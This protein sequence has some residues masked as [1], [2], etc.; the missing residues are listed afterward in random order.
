MGWPSSACSHG[1]RGARR[2]AW[3]W[4]RMPWGWFWAGW[5]TAWPGGCCPGRTGLGRIGKQAEQQGRVQ[6]FPGL[7]NAAPA[8]DK[9]GLVPVFIMLAAGSSCPHGEMQVDAV[10]LGGEVV[11]VKV[12]GGGLVELGD[13]L[14]HHGDDGG[15]AVQV[16]AVDHAGCGVGQMTDCVLTEP[17][18]QLDV[19][20]AHAAGQSLL[21]PLDDLLVVRWGGQVLLGGHAG[22]PWLGPGGAMA[23]G[24]D[25]LAGVRRWCNPCSLSI[26]ASPAAS[27]GWPGPSSPSSSW[28]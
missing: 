22:A 2:P 11:A 20:S 23:R 15:A 21:K 5:P 12:D 9:Q 6:V 18:L 4:R 10:L 28:R 13:A 3:M 19:L 27:A 16:G 1:A 24:R 25:G 14:S 7:G 8:Q 17:L 26:T